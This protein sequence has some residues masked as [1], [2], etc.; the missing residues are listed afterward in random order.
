VRAGIG[1]RLWADELSVATSAEALTLDDVPTADELATSI[2][3]TVDAVAADALVAASILAL[4]DG[5]VAVAARLARQ[6]AERAA[7][8]DDDETR[9]RA[10]VVLGL[11]QLREG[12]LG[13][14]V[15]ALRSGRDR[16]AA[17]SDTLG[18]AQC[19]HALGTAHQLRAEWDHAR[20]ALLDA[21]TSFAA[22]GRPLAA[23]GCDQQLAAVAV[24][25]GHDDEARRRALGA[26]GALDTHRYRL[27]TPAGRAAWIQLYEHTLALA[28]DVAARSGDSRVVAELIETARSQGVPESV[29]PAAVTGRGLVGA[30][31]M[32]TQSDEAMASS[33][34]AAARATAGALP[35]GPGRQ[36]SVGASSALAVFDDT[37][38]LPPVDLD[39]LRQKCGGRDATWWGTWR[40]GGRLWWSLIGPG[41]AVAVGSIDAAATSPLVSA[42]DEWESVVPLA[43]SDETAGDAARRATRGALAASP[44]AERGLALRLGLAVLPEPLR[45]GLVAAR[46]DAPIS[47]VVAPAPEIASIPVAWL[48]VDEADT[49]LVERADTVVVPAAALLAAADERWPSTLAR[50]AGPVRAAVTDALDDLPHVRGLAALATRA[51]VGADATVSSVVEVLRSARPGVVVVAGHAR[52]D[53][54][55]DAHVCVARAGEGAPCPYS[56][57]ARPCSGEPLPAATWLASDP[58]TNEAVV[59]RVLLAT[60][61]G[62]GADTAGRAGEWLGLAPALLFAGARVVV[63]TAWP[64]LDHAV[65]AAIDED[66]ARALATA[67]RPAA[68]LARIQRTW[69]DR[70]RATGWRT[71]ARAVGSP[72]VPSDHA[73]PLLWAPYVAVGFGAG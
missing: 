2:A 43:R 17:A 56:S 53:G 68:E 6:A 55:A 42:L 16:L 58:A 9:G 18:A 65:T 22:L 14:A 61:H 25:A 35:L 52:S 70:W 4:R 11:L 15:E 72:A 30:E 24:I 69:L 31:L 37:A 48:A 8:G 27:V 71:S 33:P 60:C 3:G 50:G 57:P 63:A 5:N 44:A 67:E 66:L 47:L 32:V 41:D 34:D 73:S 39:A 13:D 20:D 36:I 23:A 19:S 21:R 51:V 7:K 40:V 26:L 28:L 64:V 45:S 29:V 10:E 38:P 62:S 59:N 49:R 54:V 46:A 12:R 1:A